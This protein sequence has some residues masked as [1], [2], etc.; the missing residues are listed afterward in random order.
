VTLV[1]VGVVVRV[2]IL[3]LA[4]RGELE[5]QTRLLPLLVLLALVVLV[6]VVVVV[7]IISGL[8]LGVA[9]YKHLVLAQVGREG[10]ALLILLMLQMAGLV[11]VGLCLLVDRLGL[12]VVVM[13]AAVLPTEQ[14]VI[15]LHITAVWA[16]LA[17]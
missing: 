13:A 1:E 17:L 2:A 14:S 8:L 10:L 12:V 3:E 6:V 7:I 5:I 11:L 9:A 4:G 16:D 15:M